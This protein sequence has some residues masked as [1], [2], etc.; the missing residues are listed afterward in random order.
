MT[1]KSMYICIRAL[2]SS[3]NHISR[4]HFRTQKASQFLLSIIARM[5]LLSKAI[6]DEV[7]S[8]IELCFLVLKRSEEVGMKLNLF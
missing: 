4:I 7:H 6:E 1:L 2:D 8:F 5:S 3:I